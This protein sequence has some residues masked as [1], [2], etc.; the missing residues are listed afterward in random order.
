MDKANEERLSD[1]QISLLVFHLYFI[2]LPNIKTLP[3]FYLIF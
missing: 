3:A 2:E 1:L